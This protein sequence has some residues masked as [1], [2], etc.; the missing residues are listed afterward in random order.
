MQARTI[1]CRGKPCPQ[2]LIMTKQALDKSA[3]DE[4]IKVLLD[5]DTARSNIE[6]FLRD[7]GVAFSASV[8]KGEITLELSRGS[9]KGTP[10]A[11][12]PLEAYCA[13]APALT[14]ATVVIK[15]DYM[16]AADD[17]GGILIQAFIN[18]LPS[19]QPSPAVLIFYH[20]GIHLVCKGSPV[21]ESI[22]ACAAQGAEVLAC[23]TCLDYFKK[24]E[25]L[26]CGRISNMYDIL[27][28]LSTASKI[29]TP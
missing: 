14:G 28:R 13:P 12:T 5:N 1:D 25:Q 16:G 19:L 4:P 11:A 6:H 29:I 10:V 24:K 27:Q 26:A 7:N 18:T 21:L 8:D 3:P 17:L 9:Y 15:G 20:R 23:G 22:A 2:P